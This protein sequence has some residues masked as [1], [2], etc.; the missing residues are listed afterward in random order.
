MHLSILVHLQ[1]VP[2]GG[3]TGAFVAR[4][5]ATFQNFLSDSSCLVRVL[6]HAPRKG[7]FDEGAIIYLPQ[8]SD[9]DSYFNSYELTALTLLCTFFHHFRLTD[10]GFLRAR[11]SRW[12]GFEDPSFKQAQQPRKKPDKTSSRVPMGIIT[13]GSVRGR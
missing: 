10:F 11:S 2:K 8:P 4:T 13:S 6:I 7:V 3:E 12:Q 1:E 9:I 5:M